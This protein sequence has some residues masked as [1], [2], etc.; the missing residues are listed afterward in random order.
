MK[1]NP[2]TE[3]IQC[4][5]LF[6]SI[7]FLISSCQKE[8]TE[9]IAPIAISSS[10]P[11]DIDP[12]TQNELKAKNDN[13]YALNKEYNKFSWEVFTALFWP[14]DANGT[15]MPKFTDQGEATCLSWKESFE[16]FRCDGGT[17]SPWLSKRTSEN[18]I[19]PSKENLASSQDRFFLTTSTPAHQGFSK[20]IADEDA[21]AFSGKLFD[22]NGNE[23]YYEVLLN[24]EEFDYIVANKLYNI[25]GQIEFTK[26]NNRI[27]NFPSGD[28][29]TNKVGA[30]E[31]KFAWKILVDTDIKE[32][33]YRS[34]GYIPNPAGTG[35]IKKELGMI[36]FHISQKTTT[37]KQ[38]V[39]STFEHI[40]NLD[41]NVI[42][43]DGK[44]YV[45]HPS[46]TNPDCEI[47]PVNVNVVDPNETPSNVVFN[48]DK[49]SSYWT[50]EGDPT[51]TKYY[52]DGETFKTQAKR[53]VNI[54]IRV[55]QINK[56][57]Q[58]YFKSIGS[59]FQY[60]QLIDTQY[61]T[62]QNAKPGN[63][64]EQGYMLPESVVNKPGGDP[65]L[66][67]LTNISMETFFQKGNDNA[68]FLM[69][70][71]PKSD[72]RIFRTESCIGCHSSAGIYNGIDEKNNFTQLKQLSGDFSWLLSEK[73]K[74]DQKIPMPNIISNPE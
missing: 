36:G 4:L 25:N 54:P 12:K 17:P 40:D 52:A 15:A 48:K 51:K 8:T 59:V 43:I 53:I 27:A 58:N 64:T 29:K 10:I 24:K 46:L 41:Q 1:N 74:W 28:F 35:L 73:A 39:W 55:Q 66:A 68:S 19:E 61:P 23:V 6:I 11:V 65:N 62:D 37:A 31:I 13:F 9:I 67:L 50:I 63:N 34:F 33:Y 30:I 14:Q 16:V 22:Q 38:W 3:A 57:V 56:E 71:E 26:H 69:E 45:I 5:L 44:D 49:H 2:V 21:Q 70:A 42:Q 72:I 20:N 32:R 60:Y 47:C 18:C 7:S